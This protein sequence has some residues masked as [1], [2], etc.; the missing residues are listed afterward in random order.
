MSNVKP[1]PDGFHSLTPHMVVKGAAKA[2]E[3]Y[4]KAFGAEEV[5][6]MKDPSGQ[7]IVHGEMKIGNSI[8]MMC[9]E[10]PSCEGM[11]SPESLNGTSV[12]I[13][14]YVE[15]ADAAF[16]KALDAGAT[17]VMPLMDAFWGDRYGQ[18]KDPFG[19]RWSIATHTQDLTPEQIG[20]NAEEFFA[21]MPQ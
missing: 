13:H 20:K 7:F 12:T 19:H 10:M 6:V 2:M 9:D 14:L 18:V 16:Q 15:N 11:G 4:A 3:F 1:I 17:T 5:M 21:S 8:F